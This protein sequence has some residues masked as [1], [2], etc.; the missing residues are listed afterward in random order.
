[1]TGTEGAGVVVPDRH[2]QPGPEDGEQRPQSARPSD[3][4]RVCAHSDGAEG[5]F[6]I[7]DIRGVERSCAVWLVDQG[8]LWHRT[9]A[10]ILGKP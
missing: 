4:W 9:H 2:N 8:S 1:M 6:N 10:F 5:A 3:C 7:A